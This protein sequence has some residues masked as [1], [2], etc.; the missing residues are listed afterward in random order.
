MTTAPAITPMSTAPYL[1]VLKIV[2]TMRVTAIKPMPPPRGTA[3]RWEDRSLG[4][5]KTPLRRN[6]SSAAALAMAEARNTSAAV[7]RLAKLFTDRF[8][9]S[10]GG[11]RRSTFWLPGGG[12]QHGSI[13]V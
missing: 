11:S 2:S 1:C 4:L 9:R 3:L 10:L 13:S 6:S 5:S 8:R 12:C 7:T